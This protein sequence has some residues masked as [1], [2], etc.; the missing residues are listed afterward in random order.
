MSD[1]LSDIIKFLSN[2]K[3]Y[4]EKDIKD[5]KVIQTP[6]S[7]I[8]LTGGYAYKIKKPV[9]FGFLDFTTLDNRMHFCKRE[10]E[11]NKKLSDE[12]YLDVIPIIKS[13]G[14]VKIG[15]EGEI[16]DYAVKMKELPQD[17]IMKNLLEKNAV[18]H[19]SVGQIAKVISD[20]HS[21]QK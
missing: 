12:M 2:P 10:L 15:G 14:S 3:N 16:I 18:N 8:F 6:I 9:N 4:D 1:S 11:L 7:L 19:E 13:E 5:I 17:R 20:F 21:K